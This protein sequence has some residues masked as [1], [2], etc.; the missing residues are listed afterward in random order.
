[1]LLVACSKSK[2]PHARRARADRLYRGGLF[3]LL[4]KLADRFNL[5]VWIL[6]AKYGFI[7][8]WTLIDSYDQR[9]KGIYTGPFPKGPG[10]YCGGKD[11][12]GGSPPRYSD[13]CPLGFRSMGK[14]LQ[15]V[16]LLLVS[17]KKTLE[18]A[19]ADVHDRYQIV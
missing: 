16:K 4:M 10:Y 1:M 13:L 6:S 7:R 11:Y 14:R 5:S 15:Y 9:R 2:A 3:R 19:I 17:G 12:F 8:R 18:E